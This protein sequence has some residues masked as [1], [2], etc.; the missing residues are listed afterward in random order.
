MKIE[1]FVDREF[2]QEYMLT[3]AVQQLV[4]TVDKEIMEKIINE[5]PNEH[6]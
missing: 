6:K 1:D 5:F 2:S 3:I 4:K